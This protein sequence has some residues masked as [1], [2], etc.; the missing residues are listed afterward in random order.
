MHAELSSYYHCYTTDFYLHVLALART[1]GIGFPDWVWGRFCRMLDVLTHF[2][3]PDG[4]IPL[5]G[6]DDGGRVLALVSENYV[7]YHD[8]LCSASV[9]F[10]RPDFKYQAVTFAEESFWLLGAQARVT[11]DSLRGENPPDLRRAFKDA[12]YFIQRSGWRANDTQV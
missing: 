8:G 7:S 6:D 4:T 3:R 9:L 10:H 12:G 11:F 5:F 2:T 1:N